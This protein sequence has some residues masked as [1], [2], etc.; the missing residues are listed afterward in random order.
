MSQD[1]SP[2]TVHLVNR[3]FLGAK[4]LEYIKVLAMIQSISN[5]DIDDEREAIKSHSNQLIE[6]QKDLAVLDSFYRVTN[7]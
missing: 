2:K 3:I 6:A 1:N 7:E 5:S 4:E